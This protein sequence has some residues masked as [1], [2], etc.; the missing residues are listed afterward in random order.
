MEIQKIPE[1][2]ISEISE[3]SETFLK[4]IFLYLNSIFILNNLKNNFLIAIY[5]VY[6]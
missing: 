4:N 6:E 1:T 2:E 3:I 5:K